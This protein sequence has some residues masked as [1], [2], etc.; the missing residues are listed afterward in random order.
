MARAR[1]AGI[2]HNEA[3]G[4]NQV[5]GSTVLQ[6]HLLKLTPAQLLHLLPPLCNRDHRACHRATD[7]RA[8]A[9]DLVP[10]LDDRGRILL[11]NVDRVA[12]R[13]EGSDVTAT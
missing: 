2:P 11:R 12:L 9:V 5:L 7:H 10:L 8:T 6:R 3:E 4:S 1:S 13:S